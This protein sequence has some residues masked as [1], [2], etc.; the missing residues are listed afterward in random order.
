MAD[1]KFIMAWHSAVGPFE[2]HVI[3]RGFA[4]Q[5]CLAAIREQDKPVHIG[6]QEGIQRM[7]IHPVVFIDSEAGLLGEDLSDHIF[8]QMPNLERDTLIRPFNCGNDAD[9]IMVEIARSSIRRHIEGGS[10]I[11][12]ANPFLSPVQPLVFR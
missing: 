5:D 3:V 6:D 8:E 2:L 4:L 12:A 7:L 9:L 1:L 11:A 10:Y